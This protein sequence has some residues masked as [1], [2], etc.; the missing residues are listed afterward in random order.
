[1][2]KWKEYEE[3]YKDYNFQN[4]TAKFFWSRVIGYCLNI[5]N[6]IMT[7]KNVTKFVL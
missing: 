6:Y 7:V 3:P 5:V 2:S 4:L 1:M